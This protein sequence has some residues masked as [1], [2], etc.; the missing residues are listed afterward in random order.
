MLIISCGSEGNQTVNSKVEEGVYRLKNPKSF[1]DATVAIALRPDNWC[2][3]IGGEDD[4]RFLNKNNYWENLANGAAQLN[5]VG[6]ANNTVIVK[7]WIK[8]MVTDI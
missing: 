7:A 4:S 2:G 1:S 8:K 5:F 6:G 3:V